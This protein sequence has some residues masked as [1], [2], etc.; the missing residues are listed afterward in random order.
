MAQFRVEFVLHQASGRYLAELYH[1]ERENEV[2]VRTEPLYPTQEAALL[3]VVQLF[4]EVI[5]QVGRPHK[6]MKKAAKKKAPRKKKRARKA[7]KRRK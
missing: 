1:P 5:P 3:G 4:Q 2:M 7:S 6:P